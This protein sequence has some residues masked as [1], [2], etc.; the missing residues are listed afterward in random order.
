V[1]VL[2]VT[3]NTSLVVALGSYMR[4][5]EVVNVRTAQEAAGSAEG[6]IVAV[7]DLGDSETGIEAAD[8]L[9]QLGL[10]IPSV[11]IGDRQIDHPNV[12]MLIRP[13]SLEDL[14]AAVQEA[15][16]R[17]ITP[18][19]VPRQTTEAGSPPVA[20]SPPAA[21]PASPE[22]KQRPLSVVR[23]APESG[24]ARPEAPKPVEHL[25]PETAQQ[26]DVAAEPQ[27]AAEPPTEPTR[28]EPEERKEDRPRQP[29]VKQAPQRPAAAPP[30]RAPT[31]SVA[32]VA[33]QTAA[34]PAQPPAASEPAGRW[35]LRRKPAR[36]IGTE[37]EPE[38]PLLRRLRAVAA[39][40]HELNSLID[41]LPVIRDIR[42]L[43]DALVGEME[44]QFSAPIAA[45]FTRADDGYHAIAHRGLSRVEAGMVVI[46][47][48][49]LFSDVLRTGEGILIQP[50]D[51]A[52]GL[53]AGIGGARTEALMAAPAIL[54]D[55]V[56]AIVVVGGDRFV[57]VDLDRLTDLAS[58][59]APG[60]AVASL[61][62]RLR[63]GE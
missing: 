25:E 6:S 23:P 55:Q 13:F 49:P 45:V 1:R 40:L 18:I 44:S 9:Y 56:V 29:A 42:A 30:Q 7:I 4:D 57:E 14:S 39:Q 19:G 21:P 11:V 5:W 51:L 8:Q 10:G 28:A 24:G 47:T 62:Q 20:A 43:A 15:S 41:E 12:A 17:P 61:L 34:A 50:V 35:R 59:A 33:T 37:V 32:P 58:E 2:A 63:G 54:G 48:Q 36:P 31:P 38:P 46:E 27:P 53:V 26:K 60:L 16:Q 22:E 3:G 52:Q